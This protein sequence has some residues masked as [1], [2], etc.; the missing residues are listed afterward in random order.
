MKL[1]LG[2]RNISEISLSLFKNYLRLYHD[3][4]Y[5]PLRLLGTIQKRFAYFKGLYGNVEK[6]Q[7]Y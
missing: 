6:D 2:K 7:L 5:L 1:Y 4:T 3:F